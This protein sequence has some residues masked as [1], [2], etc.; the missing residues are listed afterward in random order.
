MLRHNLPLNCIAS[1]FTQMPPEGHAQ[2]SVLVQG[3]NTLN[4]S[5]CISRA[6]SVGLPI[7]PLALV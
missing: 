4:E 2:H 7:F 6:V 5:R 3:F 1:T